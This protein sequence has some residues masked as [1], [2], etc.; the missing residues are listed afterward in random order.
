MHIDRLARFESSGF[1]V[2][3]VYLNRHPEHASARPAL[4]DLLK[5]LRD[6]PDLDHDAQMSLRTDLESIVA[7]VER[8]DA[9]KAPA[10]A[11]FACQ[12]DGL[13]EFLPLQT[14][15]WDVAKMS[16]RPYLRPLRAIKPTGVVA[17][18]VIDRRH[19][20]L[21]RWEE[22]A[23]GLIETIDATE[24]HKG[25]YGGFSGYEERGA[26]SHAEAIE[27]RHFRQVAERLFEHHRDTPFDSVVVGGHEEM[28]ERFLSALHP[29][30]SERVIGTFVIDPHT[31]TESSIADRVEALRRNSQVEGEETIAARVTET[32]GVGGRAVLGL[33]QVLE[34]VSA[35]AV[36]H[37]V[38]AGRFTKDGV[39]C[40][41]CGRLE[42]NGGD[43]TACGSAVVKTDDVVGVAIESVLRTGGRADQ[44]SVSSLLDRHGVGALL[45]YPVHA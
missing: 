9:G 14:R 29:Y 15:V 39:M 10:V 28:F 36:D 3:S 38:V 42:R 11:I 24:E 7:Q 5:P 26:R 6:V 34:A 25:N 8:I 40:P 22:A 35:G 30:L 19:A 41:T 31:M 32:A 1:P 21:Y 27:Q 13:F 16:D 44:I 12:G 43:C 17:V 4:C 23:I 18:V 45:R 20:W 37:I 33:P 2:L